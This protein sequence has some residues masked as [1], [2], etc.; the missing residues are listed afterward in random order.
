VPANIDT[1][2]P[3]FAAFQKA[4]PRN[5]GERRAQA[6]QAKEQSSL[7]EARGPPFILDVNNLPPLLRCS[8]ICRDAKRGYPGILPMTRSAFLTAVED[9][10]IAKGIKLGA[11]VVAWRREDILEIVNNGVIGRREQGRRARE[12]A[13]QRVGAS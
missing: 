3:K 11:K 9:G 12:R 6:A 1:S 2:P 5:R 8:D 10:Y 4:M 13:A 7:P